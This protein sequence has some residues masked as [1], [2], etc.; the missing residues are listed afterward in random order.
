M[1][2]SGR[3]GPRANS[4]LTTSTMPSIE[5][6]TI[7]IEIVQ[8]L[9][10][11]WNVASTSS[12]D[13]D[14]IAVKLHGLIEAIRFYAAESTYKTNTYFT[15]E[16]QMRTWQDTPVMIDGGK[17]ARTILDQLGGNHGPEASRSGSQSE[18]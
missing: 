4:S 12:H 15:G 2:L 8:L 6:D 5:A 9:R 7:A 17:T 13:M 11:R 1:A 18:A 10:R 16:G 3:A 14:V